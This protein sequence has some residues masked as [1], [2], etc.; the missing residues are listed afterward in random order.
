MQKTFEM[1]DKLRK[2]ALRDGAEGNL[3]RATMEEI[4]DWCE[5]KRRDIGMIPK[6]CPSDDCPEGAILEEGDNGVHTCSACGRV[7]EPILYR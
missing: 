7:Y 4:C 3:D 5:E 1:L 6:Y 2:A